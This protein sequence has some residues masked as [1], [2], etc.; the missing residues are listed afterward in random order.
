MNVRGFTLLE[1]LVVIA[2]IGVLASI[3]LASVISVKKKADILYKNAQM[4]QYVHIIAAYRAATGLIAPPGTGLG[5]Y[6]LGDYGGAGAQ[7][8]RVP[9]SGFYPNGVQNDAIND[10]FAIYMPSLPKF[11]VL[12][13]DTY[14]YKFPMFTCSAFASGKCVQSYFTWIQDDTSGTFAERQARCYV[15]GADLIQSQL[16]AGMPY[17]IC[18]AIFNAS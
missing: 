11:Q 17:L 16:T 8:G 3:I 15:L 5:G 1:L 9:N 4:R 13:D 12:S 10:F 7:C 14:L 2:I 18:L 6:C